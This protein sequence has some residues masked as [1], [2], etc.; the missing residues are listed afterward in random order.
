VVPV[1]FGDATHNLG[2]PGAD[3]L[4]LNQ[5]VPAYIDGN[6][7][8]ANRYPL[9]LAVTVAARSGRPWCAVLLSRPWPILSS[10]S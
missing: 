1:L 5:L 2:I 3:D 8:A 10:A 6:G 7:T 4:Q 9:V